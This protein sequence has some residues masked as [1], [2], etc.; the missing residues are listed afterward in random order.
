[1]QLQK[2]SGG[3]WSTIKTWNKSYS[4]KSMVSANESYAGSKGCTYRMKYTI[5]VGEDNKTS[6]TPEVKVWNFWF[7]WADTQTLYGELYGSAGCCI[8]QWPFLFFRIYRE[9]KNGPFF[10]NREQNWGNATHK[11]SYGRMSPWLRNV[12]QH[13]SLFFY[14]D[15]IA[16]WWLENVRMKF[17]TKD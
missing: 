13:A 17:W 16:A 3:T 2:K 15:C 1:M 12:L 7:E 4:N 8:M 6:T 11:K 10:F 9:K 5:T 14:L